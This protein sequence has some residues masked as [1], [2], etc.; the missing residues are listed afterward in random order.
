MARPEAHNAQGL[1]MTY[2][3][4]AAF[5]RAAHDADIK[6]AIL[7]ADGRD[8]SAGH[9]LSGDG[10]SAWR[11]CPSAVKPIEPEQRLHRVPW[12]SQGE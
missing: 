4:N 7:A 9:G 6:V 5:D 2:Q 11:D 8:F 3:L 10:G 1:T 12:G